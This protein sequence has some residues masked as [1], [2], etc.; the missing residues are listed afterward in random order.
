MGAV[1]DALSHVA[2][3]LIDFISLD[4]LY[5]FLS[6]YSLALEI[7]TRLPDIISSRL[8]R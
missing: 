3:I 1:D 4:N 8:R 7:G 2:V 5:S 6:F